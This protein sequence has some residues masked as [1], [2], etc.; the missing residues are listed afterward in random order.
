[1]LD[2]KSILF[3]Y[4]KVRKQQENLINDVAEAVLNKKHLV[5]HAPTGLG[6]TVAAL[7]P[8][9]TYALKNKKTIFFLT[10]RHT[11]HMIAIE[12]LQKIKDSFDVDFTAVDIIGK[13][14]M[15]MQ[16]VEAFKGKDFSEFCKSLK[17]NN[18][19]L[20]F[21][22]TKKG[23]TKPTALAEQLI[24]DI[25]SI[26]PLHSETILKY[27]RHKELCPY[28]ISMMLAEKADVIIADYYYIFHPSIRDNFLAK[29][30]KDLND[31]IVIVDEGHNLPS[32]I[33]DLQTSRL[34]S[35]MISRAIKEAK[36]FKLEETKENL[37]QVEDVLN[38]LV[39]GI[40]KNNEDTVFKND[41]VRLVE[42]RTG[43]DYEELIS[44]F[45]L[46][47]N[48]ILAKQKISYIG[49]IASFLE[50]WLGSDEGFCR[51]ISKEKSKS[52]AYNML[53]YRC[54]DPSLVSED[55]IRK[56]HST[57]L[58]S[59]TLIP[60]SMY[61]DILG[62]PFSTIKKE[63][64]SPF[65]QDNKLTLI[66]PETTT[67]YS[68]RNEQQFMN[69][70]KICSQITAIVPGNSAI[71]FPSY[72]IKDSVA[73]Y[74]FELTD[75]KLFSESSGLSKESKKNLLERFKNEKHKGGILLGVA[76]GSFGE[77]IDLPGDLL[78]CVIVVGLPL[79]KPDL[80]TAEL[81]QYYDSKFG[82]GMDYAY[83]SP[84]LQK[85]L[86]NAGRCIRTEND[87]GVIVFL[88]VRYSWP[89]YFRIF[90]N[91]SNVRVSSEYTTIIKNFYGC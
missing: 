14:H 38:T 6:K 35:F 25:R 68:E 83:I 67:K 33:R 15:C 59:G 69:I 50:S 77:G 44:D 13:Q 46:I 37:R 65:P 28:E 17:E 11:Q 42:S 66:V 12:T 88:D 84:A 16:D 21:S 26:L 53:S 4:P 32:R 41:F 19:C 24:S 3:P 20:F 54:L 34:T 56:S 29:I 60:T 79:S 51:I 62:F 85:S 90:K 64:E 30:K 36:K 1:M 81:I 49:S 75:K 9:L 61:L 63:Y 10:S 23:H 74:L 27:C 5:V 39:S 86:Q 40:E 78:K 47:S 89:N 31:I 87:K 71:F 57:I 73:K 2:L 52:N 8:A 91:E 72:A 43:K 7:A 76:A 48:D 45:L 22:N 82:K 70:A 58:M 80:E 55:I 18:S